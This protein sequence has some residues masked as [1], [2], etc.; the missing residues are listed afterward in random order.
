MN[1]KV[2]R[3]VVRQP[4]SCVCCSHGVYVCMCVCVHLFSEACELCGR[5]G[6]KVP[7]QLS[8]VPLLIGAIAQGGAR[9]EASCSACGDS[10]SSTTATHHALSRQPPLDGMP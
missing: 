7:S 8:P 3:R 9:R 4:N 1:V 6:R 5:I 10:A 2:R